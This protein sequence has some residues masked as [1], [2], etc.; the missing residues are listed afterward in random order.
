M[1]IRINTYTSKFLAKKSI[2]SLDPP[3]G[4]SELIFAASQGG[5]QGKSICDLGK[6][7]PIIFIFLC[8]LYCFSNQKNLC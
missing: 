8:S 6:M 2:H 1:N 3:V 5:E 7:R 4:K